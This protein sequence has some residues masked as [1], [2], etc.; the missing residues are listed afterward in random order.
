MNG[1]RIIMPLTEM[2]RI[3]EEQLAVLME[4][5][6]YCANARDLAP[7]NQAICLST[8]TL[9]M[10]KNQSDAAAPAAVPF[11]LPSKEN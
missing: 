6:K 2:Q 3:I 5:C 11:Q 8:Q 10:I 1:E 7:I 4:E 9:L